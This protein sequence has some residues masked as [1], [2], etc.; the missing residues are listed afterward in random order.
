MT[1]IFHSMRVD[2]N[3]YINDIVRPNW[4]DDTDTILQ[5]WGDIGTPI[6][7]HQY[8]ESINVS[9]DDDMPF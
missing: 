5:E 3:Q 8:V 4:C 6:G 1:P 7:I 2:A 9:N